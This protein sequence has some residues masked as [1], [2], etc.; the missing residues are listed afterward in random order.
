MIYRRRRRFLN[1]DGEGINTALSYVDKFLGDEGVKADVNVK[2]PPTVFIYTG[3][4][5]FVGI[6]GAV[7][8]AK[9]LGK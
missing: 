8:V 1:A 5:L 6:V 3:V 2:I 7:L 9:K 4:A